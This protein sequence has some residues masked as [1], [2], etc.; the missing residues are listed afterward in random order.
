[1]M[2]ENKKPKFTEWFNKKLEIGSFPISNNPRFTDNTY[3]VCINVS[4][5]WYPELDSKIKAVVK[6]M[7]WF[8]MNEC[9][10]DIG[11]NSI[12]GAMIILH[13]SYMQNKTVYLHCHAGVN[14]SQAVADSFYF[15]LSGIHRETFKN[16]FINKVT[17]MCARGYLPPK[18]EFE[19]F[20]TQIRKHLNGNKLENYLGGQLDMV[21]INCINNF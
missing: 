19:K 20:L 21:K 4:D 15:M 12:Y 2:E 11:L 14:R 17:A 13:D 16:G 3:D 5:E 8:P 18:A 1:M 7:Y 9:R 10:K 6:D